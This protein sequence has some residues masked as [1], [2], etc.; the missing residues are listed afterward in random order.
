MRRPPS[1]QHRR[2]Q[3]QRKGQS[4]PLPKP[5]RQ[6]P[7][8]SLDRPRILRQLSSLI[9]PARHRQR[10]PTPP[11]ARQRPIAELAHRHIQHHRRT[12]R[13]AAGGNPNHQRIIPQRRRSGAPRREIRQRIRPAKQR[14]AGLCGLPPVASAALP[15]RRV[16]Q[17]HRAHTMLPS[18]RH[19]PCRH[20]LCRKVSRSAMPRPPLQRTPTRHLFRLSQRVDPSQPH[21]LR[22]SRQPRNPVRPHPIAVRLRNHPRSRCR[23]PLRQTHTP[24]HCPNPALKLLKPDSNHSCLTPETS[25]PQASCESAR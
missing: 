1:G 15:V 13:L 2:Q 17:R 19:R 24:Q 3:V 14:T 22:K 18:Q 5:Y 23:A 21:H 6:C 8:R 4:R 20:R 25:L 7:L 9:K 11:V 12:S 10:F 16:A